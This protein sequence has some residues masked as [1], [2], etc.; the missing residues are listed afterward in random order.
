MGVA[1]QKVDGNHKRIYVLDADNKRIQI[2]DETGAYLDTWAIPNSDGGVEDIK[3]GNGKVYVVSQNYNIHIFNSADGTAVSKS[4]YS[5]MSGRRPV[6][7]AIGADGRLY[8]TGAKISTSTLNSG[9]YILDSNANNIVETIDIDSMTDS[10]SRLDIDKDG[11][12]YVTDMFSYAVRIYGSDGT[13]LL[14]LGTPGTSGTAD[15]AFKLPKDTAVDQDGKIYVTDWSA[16]KVKVFAADGTYITSYPPSPQ[17]SALL[18][19]TAS[20]G[21]TT[22][23]TAVTISSPLGTNN[24]WVVNVSSSSLATPNV[25]DAAPTGTGVTN[26]FTPGTDI[27]GVDATTNKYVGVYELDSDDKIVSF[28]LITLTENDIKKEV[29]APV[30]DSAVSPG[31]TVGTTKVTVDSPAAGYTYA[32]AVSDSP[33]ATPNVGNAAPTGAGVTNP[34]TPGTDISGVDATT[35]KYVGVYEVDS[36]GKIVSFKQITLTEN[37]IKQEV[38]A[39]VLDAEASPGSTVGTTKVTVDSPAAGHT[40]AIVVSDSLLSTPNVGDDA[41]TGTGVMNPFTPGT[42]VSGVNATTNKYVGVYELGSDDK[43]VSFKLITLSENDIKQEVPAPV[44]DSAVGPGNTVGTTKV[45]VNSPAA[46]ST[47]AVVVSDNPLATP[48][49]GEAA[50]TGTGVTNPYTPG[51][52]V[53][54]VDATTNKYVGVYELDSDNKIVSFKLITLTEND[55]KQEVPAPVLDSAVSPGN[56]VGTTKVTVDSPA[57]GYTYA[58]AVSDSPLATPN[59]GNAAPTGT[60]VTNPYTPG[61]DVSGV[62]ATTNKYVGV[63]EVD[64]NGKVV[65]FKLI[66]L[67]VSDI[68]EEVV[69]PPVAAPALDAE[70]SPGSTVGTTKVTVDSPAAGSTY[71]VAVS[72]SPLST[73]NVGDAAPTGTGVMNPFTPG[74]DVSGVDATTNKYVGVYELDSDD[75]IMS[76]KLI[77][78]TESDIKQEVAPSWPT[79]TPSSIPVNLSIKNA[80]SPLLTQLNSKLGSSVKI[81]GELLTADGKTIPGSSIK[82]DQNGAIT[83]T[84][85]EPGV[86]KVVLSTVAPDGRKLVGNTATITV[87]ANGNARME[88]DLV[89]PFGVASDP[90]TGEPIDGMRMTLYWADTELNRSKGRA[91]GTVVNLP[92]LPD[93]SPNQNN[94]PQVTRDGGQYGWMVYA[95]GDYYFT[96]EKDGYV[97]YDSR[98]DKRNELHGDTSYIRDGIIHVGQSIVRVDFGADAA[99][100]GTGVHTPYLYGYPDKQFKPELLITRAEVAA[101]LARILPQVDASAII[102]PYSDVSDKHWAYKDIAYIRQLGIMNGTPGNRFMSNQSIT[103]AEF[104]QILFK[105]NPSLIAK[106]N[107]YSDTGE[108]W[109]REAIDRVTGAGLMQGFG[110]GT[111]KPNAQVTRAEAATIINRYLQRKPL[112]ADTSIWPDVPQGHWAASDIAEASLSHSYS[113]LSNGWEVWELE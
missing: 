113:L 50:P 47:Y 13:P 39:P 105:L 73:P 56:A 16:H 48:N 85:V 9:I 62:D 90:I 42:D 51:T 97:T 2:F 11:K 72:D 10:S 108:H 59:V 24:H 20:P 28:K 78:L 15:N 6:G 4:I 44:L 84:S 18:N 77:T 60:G 91:P 43:I 32:V 40:Y 82:F 53:S 26:P 33:L 79:T 41:P 1:V 81:E 74:T 58:V 46:G 111:F 8:I 83:M 64:S 27:S 98:N 54:G 61:T 5:L 92:L 66:T 93:M 29:P 76:F 94:N 21:S 14:T 67:T 89:D 68:K 38:P 80:D 112:N 23:T 69:I 30:L 31:S 35:N 102:Q 107:V 75:K 110:D 104:A 95:E 17:P 37:D 99:V 45:T 7:L 55:I 34:F 100:V 70:V 106:G 49:V 103:R 96:A 71:A 25:G 88:S 52:D 101:I 109:A 12:F 57:A 19:A 3:I 36:N 65:S 86:Y 22:G 63:Y 87:D